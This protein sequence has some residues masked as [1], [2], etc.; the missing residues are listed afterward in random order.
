MANY[1]SE[2]SYLIPIPEHSDASLTDF[3]HPWSDEG[4]EI[5]I[6]TERYW[7]N[8]GDIETALMFT[9]AALNHFDIDGALLVSVSLS[10]SKPRLEAFGGLVYLVT[11]EEIDAVDPIAEASQ[12]AEGAGIPIIDTGD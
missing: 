6:E 10:C 7:V 12:R 9:Q 4:F 5:V 11:K 3:A 2:F 8:G 1:Y